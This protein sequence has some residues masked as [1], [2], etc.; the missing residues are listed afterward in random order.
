MLA[1]MQIEHKVCQRSLEL[2]A[3]IPV[4]GKACAGELHGAFQVQHAE[5]FTKFPMRL[6]SES[7]C[8]RRA[9]A[10]NFYIIVRTQADRH[11]R[12]RH[13]WDSGKNIPQAGIKIGSSF[14]PRLNLVAQVFGLCDRGSSI[15]PAFLEFGYVLRG[16]VPSRLHRLGFSDG[17]PA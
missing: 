5:L 1:R 11:A 14:L 9:P 4:H 15:L 7:E 12:I 8:E 6:W 17:L 2:R 13:V 3:Q 16:L 10:A